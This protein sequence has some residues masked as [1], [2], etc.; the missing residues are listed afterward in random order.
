MWKNCL[1]PSITFPSRHTTT[2]NY[3]SLALRS[4]H[5]NDQVPQLVVNPDSYHIRKH[6]LVL[7]VNFRWLLSVTHKSNLLRKYTQSPSQLQVLAPQSLLMMQLQPP[8]LS[9]KQHNPR[10]DYKSHIFQAAHHQTLKELQSNYLINILAI[11]DIWISR[12]ITVNWYACTIVFE[13]KFKGIVAILM[14]L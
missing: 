1:R 4:V 7:L 11:T 8:L 3:V 9:N 14:E 10:L 5:T 13:R 2:P 6:L 12:Y